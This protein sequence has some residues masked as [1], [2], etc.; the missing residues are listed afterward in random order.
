VQEGVAVLFASHYVFD[1]NYR[2][3]LKN[4]LQLVETIFLHLNSKVKVSIHFGETLSKLNKI[5]D[6]GGA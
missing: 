2:R 6:D 1:M 4:T 3:G 5:I